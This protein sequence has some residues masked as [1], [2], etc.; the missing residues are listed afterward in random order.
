MVN[1]NPLVL[2]ALNGYYRDKREA[3]E[4]LGKWPAKVS[5]V[6]DLRHPA[7]FNLGRCL[8]SLLYQSYT[9][10]EFIV[11]TNGELP[12]TQAQYLAGLAKYHPFKFE[13]LGQLAGCLVA[14][15][16][17]QASLAGGVVE[18]DLPSLWKQT[19][20]KVAILA[21][22]LWLMTVEPV[23]EGDA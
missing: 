10:L 13:R 17:A 18:A 12:A 23:S 9:A 1:D 16:L 15:D 5:V 3:D 20:G 7:H 2:A 6:I 11:L 14:T 22:Q 19:A 4:L 21:A 8:S